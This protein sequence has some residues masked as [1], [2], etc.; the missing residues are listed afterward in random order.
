M[1]TLATQMIAMTMMQTRDRLPL[2][3]A[4]L[5]KRTSFVRHTRLMASDRLALPAVG[6]LV[7]DDL[8]RLEAS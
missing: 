5:L 3:R 6:V 8:S 2:L 1:V 7:A 4:L